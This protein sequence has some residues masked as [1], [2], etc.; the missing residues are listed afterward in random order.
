M[1]QPT[2]TAL[3]MEKGRRRRRRRRRKRRRKRERETVLMMRRKGGRKRMT[4]VDSH[5]FHGC[6]YSSEVWLGELRVWGIGH[7]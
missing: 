6:T 5:W 7:Q 2:E 1:R 3:S 4:S